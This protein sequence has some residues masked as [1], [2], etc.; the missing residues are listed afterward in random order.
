MSG[1]GRARR[2]KASHGGARG[3]GAGNAG[4]EAGSE[5]GTALVV[6][7]DDCSL[8]RLRLLRR[9]FRHCFVAVRSGAGW[10]ICDPLSNCT[11]L[12]FVADATAADLA[13]WYRGHG[14]QVVETRDRGAAAPPGAGPPLYLR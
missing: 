7:A 8:R 11:D 13:R 4:S 5:A 2:P 9:G 1:E 12:A 10:V 3:A 6:F 14:L